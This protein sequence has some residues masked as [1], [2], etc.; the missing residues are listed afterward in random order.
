MAER[1]ARAHPFVKLPPPTPTVAPTPIA[2]PVPQ[3]AGEPS[4]WKGILGTVILGAASVAFG[5]FTGVP[6]PFA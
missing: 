6:L 4:S 5:A 1:I 2:T 3:P